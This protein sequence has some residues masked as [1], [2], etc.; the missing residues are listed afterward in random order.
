[1]C[2][3][4]ALISFMTVVS[5]NRVKHASKAHWPQAHLLEKIQKE[6]TKV[7]SLHYFLHLHVFL[8]SIISE[9]PILLVPVMS[10]HHCPLCC[11]TVMS[12]TIML[13]IKVLGNKYIKSL[14]FSLPFGSL[15]HHLFWWPYQCFLTCQGKMQR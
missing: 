4:P 2:Y 12:H 11:H 14:Q 15:S 13:S 8:F 7:H 5:E 1:M 3:L 9:Y 10:S 6:I